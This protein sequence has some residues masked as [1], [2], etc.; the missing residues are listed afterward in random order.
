MH[1]VV[2]GIQEVD[3]ENKSG[4]RVQGKR[5]FLTYESDKILGSGVEAVYIPQRVE[6]DVKIG[7]T[8]NILYNRFGKVDKVVI[9]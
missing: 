3:Y 2:V 7:D 6:C 1:E 8:I 9:V 5:L 4:L